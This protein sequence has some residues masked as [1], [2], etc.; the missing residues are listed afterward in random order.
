MDFQLKTFSPLL[1]QPL[2]EYLNSLDNNHLPRPEANEATITILP[3]QDKDVLEASNY[4]PI[5]LINTDM[6]ILAKI[7]TNRLKTVEEELLSDSQAGFRTNRGCRDNIAKLISIIHQTQIHKEKTILIFLDAEKAF[8][9]VSWQFLRN[10]L[11]KIGVGKWCLE[12]MSAL[13]SN[14]TATININGKKSPKFNIQNGTRQGCPLSPT[15]F[16]L[17]MDSLIR[18]INQNKEIKGVKTVSG[19]L[20]TMAYADDVIICITDPAKSIKPLM[21]L[22]KA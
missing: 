1:I 2:T 14:L 18:H 13:Y 8:D 4:R 17:Y 10:L 3:K 22:K 5:S 21:W 6:K 12:K 11:R 7:V 19:E 15:L 20:K 16:N 9:R